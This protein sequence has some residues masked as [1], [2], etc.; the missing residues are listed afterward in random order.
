M[1]KIKFRA[2]NE[3]TK[4]YS[5]PFGLK[6]TVIN[7][8]DDDGLG[9]IKSLTDEIVEQYIGILDVA[10]EEMCEGDVIK[11]ENELGRKHLYKIWRS[12]GGF[13]FNMFS[14]DFDKNTEDISFVSG[15]SEMQSVGWLRQCNIVGTVLKGFKDE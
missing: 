13:V 14:N 3:S 10:G 1:D 6:A 4:R 8:L 15:C 12:E 9:V 5:K 7:F 11:Y 2:W